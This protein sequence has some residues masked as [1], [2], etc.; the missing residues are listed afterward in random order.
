MH[1]LPQTHARNTSTSKTMPSAAPLPT[2]SRQWRAIQTGDVKLRDILLSEQALPPL[3]STD[4]LI[5]VRAVSLNHTEKLVS[6]GNFPGSSLDVVPCSDLAG[7]IIAL[8]QDVSSFKTGDRVSAG[9]LLGF[10]E[11]TLGDT[12]FR[13]TGTGIY[14]DGVLSEYKVLPAESVVTVP[15]HLTYEEACTLSCVAITAYNAL[16]GGPKHV[17]KGDTVLV[18]GSGNLSLFAAQFATTMGADV[19][20]T[21]S[22]DEKIAQLKEL[23][24]EKFVNWKTTPE[25]DKE[26]H[27]LTNGRGVSHII[28][29]GGMGTLGKSISAI[30][31]GGWIHVVGFLAENTTDVDL[32]YQ[33]IMKT[34]IIRGVFVGPTTMFQEMNDFISERQLRP[35]LDKVFDFDQ[36]PQA[37]AYLS[38]SER[39]GKIVIR[40]P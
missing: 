28:E 18:L 37:Y 6:E 21:S 12:T 35:V 16:L 1:L 24:Y 22:S 19:I 8:G 20:F 11:G 3:G 40:I 36:V 15:D 9:R 23:G 10:V 2:T 29:N 31:M 33:A 38:S 14:I 4:V 27:K 32:T 25:W 30:S 17:E 5:R 34:C 7:D 26:V 13:N 39:L